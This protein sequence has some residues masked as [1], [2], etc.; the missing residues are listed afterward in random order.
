MFFEFSEEK[1]ITS[2]INVV[3]D[4][5]C[6]ILAGHRRIYGLVNHSNL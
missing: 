4:D 5:Y 1:A 6:P 3:L 2:V